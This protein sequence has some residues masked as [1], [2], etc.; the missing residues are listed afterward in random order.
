M[1]KL[2]DHDLLLKEFKRNIHK[3]MGFGLLNM[4]SVRY[5]DG[6]CHADYE[7]VF[8]YMAHTI[9]YDGEFYILKHYDHDQRG[10]WCSN[11]S[12]ERCFLQTFLHLDLSKD[13]RFI[14]LADETRYVDNIF[15][16]DPSLSVGK[17]NK[18]H[19]PSGVRLNIH[20]VLTSENRHLINKLQI[21]ADCMTTNIF[22][23]DTRRIY[24]LTLDASLEVQVESVEL[25][26]ITVNLSHLLTDTE[27]ICCTGIILEP[28]KYQAVIEVVSEKSRY[29]PM[30]TFLGSEREGYLTYCHMIEVDDDLNIDSQLYLFKHKSLALLKRNN[31]I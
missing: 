20:L 12:L 10:I 30:P 25:A 15:I 9:E 17:T 3:H 21:G 6:R 18:T 22:E 19:Y 28:K 24:L 7:D 16:R 2:V 14:F 26:T 13:K 29:D 23:I 1:E 31:I 11:S 27:W 4:E 5:E 8:G